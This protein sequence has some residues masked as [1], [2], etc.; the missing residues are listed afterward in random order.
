MAKKTKPD[1]QFKPVPVPATDWKVTDE[2]SEAVM[3][4]I[5]LSCDDVKAV[6]LFR[7]QEDLWL[8]VVNVPS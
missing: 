7:A 4:F 6:Y 2:P 1:D 3:R 8:R 5:A